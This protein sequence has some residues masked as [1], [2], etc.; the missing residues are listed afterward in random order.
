MLKKRAMRM[1]AFTMLEVLVVTGIMMSQANNYGDVKKIAYQVSCHN[2]LEQ[3][4]QA[5]QMYDTN[6]GAAPQ[7][8]FY[9]KNPKTDANSIVK[10]FDATYQPM[11][12]CPVFPSAIKDT[13][14]T[15]L[16]NDT[17]AGQSLDSVGDGAHTWLLMEMNAVS[18]KIPMPHPGGFHILYC[19]GH[20]ERTKQIPSVFTE[21]QKQALDQQGKDGANKGGGKGAKGKGGKGTKGAK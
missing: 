21:L 2:N 20:I 16:Y 11:F 4:W 8:T 9:P 10:A 19:D 5:F 3:L 18:D 7:A 15:Y 14:L 12:V 1:S 17:V 6:N 13:G